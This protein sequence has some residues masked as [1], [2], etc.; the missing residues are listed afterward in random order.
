MWGSSRCQR[1]GL[2]LMCC[3]NKCQQW[4]LPPHPGSALGLGCLCVPWWSL[5]SDHGCPRCSV[6]LTWSEQGQS[7]CLACAGACSEVAGNLAAARADLCPPFL[8]GQAR[9]CAAHECSPGFPPT[10]CYSLVSSNQPRGL[11]ASVKDPRNMASSLWLSPLTP[12]GWGPPVY[13]SFSSESHPRGT[14]SNRVLFFPS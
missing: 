13:S 5:L 10:S 14:G 8:G 11:V 7:I 3:L 1:S 12:Q 6:V 9:V 4:L 2:P